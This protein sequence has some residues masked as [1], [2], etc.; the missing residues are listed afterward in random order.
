M[1]C[2]LWK[3]RPRKGHLG[4]GCPVVLLSSPFQLVTLHWIELDLLL[5]CIGFA[6]ICMYGFWWC[7]LV[8]ENG[9]RPRVYVRGKSHGH[10]A[11]VLAL[12]FFSILWTF[13]GIVICWCRKPAD[14]SKTQK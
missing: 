8:W 14:Q 11:G 13:G 7:D 5:D 10:N 1:W 6:Y 3:V 9:K 4:P 12:A 2:G